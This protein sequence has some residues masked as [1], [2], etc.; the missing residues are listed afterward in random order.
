M[1]RPF[2]Q[3]ARLP[4]VGSLLAVVSPTAADLYV[5]G[6]R[7]ARVTG[8]GVPDLKPGR[9]EVEARWPDGRRRSAVAEVEPGQRATVVLSCDLQTLS[10]QVVAPDGGSNSQ[11]FTDRNGRIWLV[12]DDMC[13][14]N[15]T[16]LDV[17]SNLYYATSIDGTGWSRPRR[18][19]MSLLDCDTM[20]IL[21][22][23]R[24]GVFWLLWVSNRD[25]NAPKTPWIASSPNGVEW[26]F[27]RKLVLPE[28]KKG[29]SA[30]WTITTI[31]PRPAFAIDARN[32]FWLIWQGC[33][34]RSEDAVHWQVDPLWQ[35]RDNRT[36]GDV[37]ECHLFAPA[38]GLLLVAN[39]GSTLWRLEGGQRWRKLGCLCDWSFSENAGNAACRGDGTVLTVTQ[40]FGEKAGVGTSLGLCI[41]QFATDGPKP[42]PL[43]FESAGSMSFH[44]CLASL[45]GG[46]ILVAFGSKDGLVATVLRKAEAEDDVQ[47]GKSTGQ[48]KGQR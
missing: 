21:Q 1:L 34:M 40:Y 39:P 32:I 19:P 28:A 30:S 43:C 41:R 26:S 22:Q 36:P 13:G 47:D 38:D 44:P 12:W 42:K 3:P 2:S 29:E 24:R 15:L 14:G 4:N 37:W 16:H 33:L 25:P 23:D 18:M 20:P 8:V 5:N 10:R 46:R 9:Y 17:E 31:M 48:A 45:P 11:L 6:K 27:P 7:L 35:T